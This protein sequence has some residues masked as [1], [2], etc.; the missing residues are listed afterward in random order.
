[1]ARRE[2]SR[3]ELSR[4]L[5]QKGADTS[6][7]DAVL[8]TLAKQGLQSDARFVENVIHYYRNRG[9]GP[10]Y[11]RSTLIERGIREDMIEDLLNISDNTWL[12]AVKQVWQKKFKNTLPSDYKERAKQMRFLNYRGFTFEQINSVINGDA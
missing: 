3:T 8:D 5:Q 4:K 2:H 11:I 1:M 6:N 10:I 7:I 9:Y 12:T